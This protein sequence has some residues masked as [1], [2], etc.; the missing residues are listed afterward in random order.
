MKVTPKPPTLAEIA[1]SAG[2]STATVSRVLKSRGY[3]AEDTRAK[4]AEVLRDAR[5]RPNVMASSLRTQRSFSIGLIVPAITSNP[6]FVN[7]AHAVEEEALKHGYKTI[8][9]NHNGDET[10]ERQGIERLLERRMDALLVCNATAA[11]N[12]EL[13]LGAGVAV[14]QIERETSARTMAVIADNYRGAREAMAHLIGLGHRRIAFLGGDPAKLPYHGPQAMSVEEQRLAAYRE[15]LEEAGIALRPDYVRLGRYYDIPAGS[16]RYG[17]DHMQALLE[18]D[19]RPTAV[20]A[21]CDVLA[22][23]VLQALHCRPP[24]RAGRDVGDRLRRHPRRQPHAGAH[25]GRAADA[26]HGR[27]GVPAGDGGPRRG[28]DA[29]HRNLADLGRPSRLNRPRVEIG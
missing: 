16:G 15:A 21:T 20:F 19:E 18:L 11:A 7:V 26:R 27:R 3:V 9:F 28:D 12:V 22:A 5:Y 29:A 23:G 13:A 10:L 25:H 14:V 1:R 2:V 4:V 8:I 6:F 24:A 17:R